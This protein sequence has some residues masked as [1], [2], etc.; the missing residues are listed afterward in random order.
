MTPFT[1]NYTES[2]SN[3]KKVME[4]SVREGPGESF[5][6]MGIF[7]RKKFPYLKWDIISFF[8]LTFFRASRG[9]GAK[10]GAVFRIMPLFQ[11]NVLP[12]LYI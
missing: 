4:I 3:K 1:A 11:R 8:I 7:W 2:T 9:G 5:Q 10:E 12:S 6:N